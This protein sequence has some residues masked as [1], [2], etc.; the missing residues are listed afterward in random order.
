VSEIVV[1]FGFFASLWGGCSYYLY[2]HSSLS[3]IAR[4]LDALLLFPI[5]AILVVANGILTAW[6]APTLLSVI[7]TLIEYSVPSVV[8]APF[9]FFLVGPLPVLAFVA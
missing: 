7:E 8:V 2:K 3:G 1:V 6:V 4:W 5:I 9:A